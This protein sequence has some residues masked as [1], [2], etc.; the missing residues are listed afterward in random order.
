MP[1]DVFSRIV[2]IELPK[3]VDGLRTAEHPIQLRHAVETAEGVFASRMKRTVKGNDPAGLTG[4]HAFGQSWNDER[5]DYEEGYGLGSQFSSQTSNGSGLQSASTSTS[6]FPVLPAEKIIEMID[7][8]FEVRK[9]P[10]LAPHCTR[11]NRWRVSQP[12]SCPFMAAQL[13]SVIQKVIDRFDSFRLPLAQSTT[14]FIMADPVRPCSSP[15]PLPLPTYA[16]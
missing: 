1:A 2:Q 7:A 10:Q 11:L 3:I 16:T 5:D 8:G 4:W 9:N 6:C 15:Q 14:L 12:A 13:D